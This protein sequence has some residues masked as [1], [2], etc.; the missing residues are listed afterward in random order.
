VIVDQMTIWQAASADSS[1]WVILWGTMVTLPMIIGYT[2]FSYRVF[3]GKAQAL[4]YG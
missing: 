1:L 2:I 4:S 3:S